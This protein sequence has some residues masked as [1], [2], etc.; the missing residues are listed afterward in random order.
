MSVRSEQLE[1][2]RHHD[3]P[4]ALTIRSAFDPSGWQRAPQGCSVTVLP[5]DEARSVARRLRDLKYRLAL[6]AMP[7]G[8]D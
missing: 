4:S 2:D 8:D 6:A 1:P 3:E 5:S 7:A